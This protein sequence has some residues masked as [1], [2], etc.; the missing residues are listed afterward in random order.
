MSSYAVTLTYSPA[1][2]VAGP[3]PNGEDLEQLVTTARDLRSMTG[4]G[5]RLYEDVQLVDGPQDAG[6]TTMVRFSIR[7]DP[8][9]EYGA[10]NIARGLASR[11]F[12]EAKTPGELREVN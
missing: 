6:K 5:R 10:A 3:V 7:L 8:A 11:A 12:S 9:P 2:D 1:R 4:S